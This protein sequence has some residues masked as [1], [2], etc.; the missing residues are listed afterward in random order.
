MSNATAINVLPA[1]AGAE[2]KEN[3]APNG[4]LE[5]VQSGWIN[6]RAIAGLVVKE[7]FRRKDFYV[8]FVLTAL[9]TLILGSV[10]FFNGDHIVR[11]LKE[12]CLFLIWTASLV[13]AITTLSLIHISEPTRLLS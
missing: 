13:I 8:L 12:I 9:I 7:L 3:N 6:S 11:Y 10:N 2:R 5:A 4:V 1:P